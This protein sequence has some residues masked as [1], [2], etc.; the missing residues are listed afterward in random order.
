MSLTHARGMF[1]CG[2]DQ[3]EGTEEMSARHRLKVGYVGVSITPYFAEKYRVREL[4]IAALRGCAQELD[5]D[6][7][8]IERPIHSVEDAQQAAREIKAAGVDFLLLQNAACS[9]GEQL[10]PF[11]DAAPKLGLWSVPDPQQSGPVQLH[12]MVSMSHY[13]S[14]IKST[15][16]GRDIPFKWFYGAADSEKFNARFSVTVKAVRA[17]KNLRAARVGWIGGVS[18]GFDGMIPDEAG[19]Q[20]NLGLSIDEMDMA[21]IVKRADAL[22]ADRVQQAA[23]QIAGAAR[24]VV[25]SDPSS[26]E[27]VTRFYLALLDTSEEMQLDAMAVQCWSTIQELYN[28]APCMAYS[29]LG[30]DHN[31]PVSCEGDVLGAISMYMLNLISGKEGS[32][33]LLDLASLD[34]DRQAMQMWHCG[35]TPRHFANSDGIAWVDHVT[36]GRNGTDGPYGV[37]GDQI[38]APQPVT[39]SYI[40]EDA[41]QLLVLGSDVVDHPDAGYDGTRGWVSNLRMNGQEIDIWD[42][43]N[44][45]TVKGV[46]HHFAMGQGDMSSELMELA[47]WTRMKLLEPIPYADHVQLDGV[48]V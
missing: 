30:S 8:A 39:I 36:L 12:S 23:A 5:F 47:A 10:Y 14:L 33:T 35:V 16:K 17:E 27:R 45:L 11:I 46:Q 40:N 21:S 34:P 42:L 2:W 13:A 29:W 38:F 32:S 18:P 7:V 37:S 24:E 22:D 1:L 25:L 3:S 28:I 26:F 41:G 19:M 15:F 44:T 48:N 6:L 31:F 20:A 9:M 43:I 4:A